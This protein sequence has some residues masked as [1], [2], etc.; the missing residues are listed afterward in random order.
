[1]T[2]LLI[3]DLQRKKTEMVFFSN[4]SGKTEMF[5]FSHDPVS[6]N[7]VFGVPGSIKN[8]FMLHAKQ[9]TQTTP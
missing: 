4:S 1:V 9:E 8:I 6:T 5:F 3:V 2:T 7:M